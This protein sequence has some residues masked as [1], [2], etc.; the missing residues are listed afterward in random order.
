MVG[1]K[2]IAVMGDVPIGKRHGADLVITGR[3]IIN[4]WEIPLAR[5]YV[6]RA[7]RNKLPCLHFYFKDIGV[8]H[9]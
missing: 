1:T 7:D 9:I 6:R 4:V 2:G 3:E 5:R 8:R